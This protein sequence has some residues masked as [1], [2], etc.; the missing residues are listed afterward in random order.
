MLVQADPGSR[1]R[2]SIEGREP[3]RLAYD[4]YEVRHTYTRINTNANANA[5]T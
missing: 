2:G 5:P 4:V 1:L 3:L